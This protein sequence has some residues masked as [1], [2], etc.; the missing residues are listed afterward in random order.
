MRWQIVLAI[1][2]AFSFGSNFPDK[3]HYIEWLET[4]FIRL[5]KISVIQLVL[6]S[7]I[8]V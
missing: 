1:L 4:I 6:S 7:L 5:L 2:L 3:I 8:V